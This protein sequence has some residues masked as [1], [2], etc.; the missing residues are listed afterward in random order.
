MEF[1]GGGWVAGATCMI[2]AFWSQLLALA[3]AAFVCGE[4]MSYAR[5]IEIA[6]LLGCSA[7]RLLGCSSMKIESS[8][9]V[10]FGRGEG[11]GAGPWLNRFAS[12]SL[13]SMP[14]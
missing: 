10:V 12:L 7:A 3:F 13:H 11:G 8:L 6:R 2:V 9:G 14:T 5:T 4:K 1:G